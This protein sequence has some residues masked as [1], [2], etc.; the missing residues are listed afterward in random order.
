MWE[1]KCKITQTET[2]QM[3]KK[4]SDWKKFYRRILHSGVCTPIMFIFAVVMVAG[5]LGM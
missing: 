3:K 1:E 4:L 2:R 5:E